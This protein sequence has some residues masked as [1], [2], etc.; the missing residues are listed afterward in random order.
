MC[1]IYTLFFY[2]AVPIIL[3]RLWWRARKAPAYRQLPIADFLWHVLH[4]VLPTGLRRV[5]DYGFLHGK[6]KRRLTLVQR[7]LCVLIAAREQKPRPPMC[8]PHCQ[9]P[10]IVR[11]WYNIEQY[12]LNDAGHCN[13]CGTAIAGR[14]SAFTGQFGP[15]RIPLHIAS[16]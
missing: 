4:H 14:F 12:A 1:L 16:Y 10:L 15:R 3:L 6:A 9:T 2:L 11:D 5:R 8:C 13:H 7:I